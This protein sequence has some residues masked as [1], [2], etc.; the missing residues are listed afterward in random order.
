MIKLNKIASFYFLFYN[1]CSG[2][3]MTDYKIIIERFMEET[4]LDIHPNILVIIAYGSRITKTNQKNSDLD[5]FMITS[6]N[7]NYKIKRIIDGYSVECNIF[8]IHN[9]EQLIEENYYNKNFYFNSVIQNGIVIKNM[10]Y[11]GEW[12]ESILMN[13]SYS[14]TTK[15]QKISRKQLAELNDLYFSFQDAYEKQDLV[16]GKYYY[17]NLMEC[18]RRIYHKKY[19]FSPIS[20]F[21]IFNIYS[22]KEQYIKQYLSSLPNDDFISKYQSAITKQLFMEQEQTINEFLEMLHIEL[23]EESLVMEKELFLSKCE[24]KY[25]LLTLHDKL[26]KVIESLM[27]DDSWQ[28]AIYYVFLNQLCQFYNMLYKERDP[29]FEELFQSALSTKDKNKR[30]FLLEQLF[31]LVDKD[32]CFDY[33]DCEVVQKNFSSSF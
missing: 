12:V 15:K 33:D 22:H 27:R 6:Q 4:K 26:C 10:D 18:I 17:Y 14:V 8:S 25:S 16:L 31:L 30:I 1:K 7:E 29:F 9:L 5:L 28:E 20:T 32:Y 11:T 2:G 3:F 23:G 21:K 19:S 24:I 13:V